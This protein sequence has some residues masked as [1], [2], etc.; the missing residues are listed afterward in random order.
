MESIINTAGN[1]KSGILG[2]ENDFKDTSALFKLLQ[3]SF[4]QI[5]RVQDL[6][7][8]VKVELLIGKAFEEKRVTVDDK[9]FTANKIPNE[10]YD[11]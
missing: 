4:H 2:K 3:E 6:E 5:S 10:V 8:R 11:S 7:S 1:T 9:Y